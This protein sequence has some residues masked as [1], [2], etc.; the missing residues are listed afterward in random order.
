MCAYYIYIYIYRYIYNI[1]CVYIYIYSYDILWHDMILYDILWYDDMIYI[2]DILWYM[3]DWYERLWYDMI[4]R[5]DIYD[6]LYN[7]I[8]YDMIGDIMMISDMILWYR[9]IM[10]W[11]DM[12]YYDIW[13]DIW[14]YDRIF[15]WW[16]MLCYDDMLY[17]LW[18]DNYDDLLWYAMICSVCLAPLLL[19]AFI[20]NGVAPPSSSTIIVSFSLQDLFSVNTDSGALISD[21]WLVFN[22]WI[23]SLLIVKWHS[24]GSSDWIRWVWWWSLTGHD[25][26][27]WVSRHSSVISAHN[28]HDDIEAII[29]AR[30]SNATNVN[31]WQKIMSLNAGFSRIV[32]CNIVAFSYISPRLVL[33][34]IKM[35]SFLNINIS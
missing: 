34:Y 30:H 20:G 31:K 7:L 27:T 9:S 11:Y 28:Y 13:Y 1:V 15:D 12:I 10:I 5:Y 26:F 22:N 24:S 21:P 17:L 14:W 4:W 35:L 8:L 32:M 18:Y 19:V 3:I 29:T 25:A 16:Y 2:I 23:W 6:I 33:Y